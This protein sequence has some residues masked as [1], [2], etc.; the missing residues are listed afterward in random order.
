VLRRSTVTP[1]PARPD[2]K[3][4]LG[5]LHANR[6][7]IA[8]GAFAA[9]AAFTGLP[10]AAA[11]LTPPPPALAV[12]QTLEVPAYALQPIIE[13]DAFG[14]TTYSVVQWPV[15]AG[16]EITSYYGYRSCA[17]CSTDHL[18]I[19]FTPGAGTPVQ[20]IADGVVVEAVYEGVYGVHVIIEHVINGQSLRTLYAH[21][22]DGSMAVAVGQQVPRG[23]VVGAVGSTGQSTGPHLHF[24]VMIGEDY[25]DP[26]PWLLANVNI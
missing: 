22:Q 21:L 26:Y 23:T 15:A 20:A 17:G 9:I 5:A 14:I 25:V 6:G 18:G 11:A 19:D 10:A 4:R 24:G 8:F 2:I 3:R 7:L 1:P 13:R 12:A 16:S